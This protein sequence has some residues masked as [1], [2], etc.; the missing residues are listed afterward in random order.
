MNTLPSYNGDWHAFPYI[1][2]GQCG[3][4]LSAGWSAARGLEIAG[5][6]EWSQLDL[7]VRDLA[8]ACGVKGCFGLFNV[9]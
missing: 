6:S 2:V 9:E 8:M 1:L 5:G 3:K 4:G 7:E